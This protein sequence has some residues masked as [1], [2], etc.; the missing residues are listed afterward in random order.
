MKL[1]DLLGGK[2]HHESPAEESLRQAQQAF[3][4]GN[5]QEAVRFLTTGFQ[6]DVDHQPLYPLAAKCLRELGGEA[7][8]GLFDQAAQN[9]KSFQAFLDLGMFFQD[10]NHYD[11]AIS[12]ME[13]ANKLNPR[14]LEL[15]HDLAVAYAR[16]FEVGKALDVLDKVGTHHDFWAF[17]FWLKLRIMTGQVSDGITQGLDDLRSG[18]DE[19]ED[20]EELLIPRLKVEEVREMLARYR[21][22]GSPRQH[23]RDWHYIQ[24][25]SMILE[26]F[27]SEGDF[28]AGGR[29][30][31]SWGS[32]EM[33]KAVALRLKRYLDACTMTFREVRYLE[34]RD[35]VILGRLLAAVLELPGNPY[36]PGTESGHCLIVGA[37]ATDFDGHEELAHIREGQVLFAFNQ[38]WLES[39]TVT[40]DIIGLMSQFF[41]FPW[42]GGGLRIK[43]DDPAGGLESIPA[44]EREPEEIVAELLALEVEE[45][46]D[47][48]HL[49]F[50]LQHRDYLKAIG[51]LASDIRFNFMI[52]SPVPGSRFA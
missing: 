22:V 52:E 5:Y 3:V 7:E 51:R 24:Y 47:P 29:H 46:H 23:I 14:H 28:V 41:S 43:G 19:M 44:D 27:E 10:L 36:D 37:N 38:S 17:W 12:F 6:Q 31:A 26:F 13:K 9:P 34:D 48:A 21:L 45:T 16:R 1:T 42:D 30:V 8:V 15:A 20:S 2:Q 32:R 39:A 33:I 4:E 40:P 11:L 50:Y 25:G 35:T 18:L 49:D